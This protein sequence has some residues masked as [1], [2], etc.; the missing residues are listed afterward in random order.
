MRNL[1]PKIVVILNHERATFMCKIC[2]K[3]W[4]P[5]ILKDGRLGRGSWQCPNG[6]KPKASKEP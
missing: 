3:I 1:N 5:K 2:G 4:S 6:C